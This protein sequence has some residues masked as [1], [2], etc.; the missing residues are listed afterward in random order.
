MANRKTDGWIWAFKRSRDLVTHISNNLLLLI[1][2]I[3]IDLL[4]MRDGKNILFTST[5]VFLKLE[6]SAW[7]EYTLQSSM[8]EANFNN[9]S[10]PPIVTWYFPAKH[11]NLTRLRLCLHV[12]CACPSASTSTSTLTLSQ[13]LTQGMGFR[14]ILCVC[15]CV[16]ISTT[17]KL[18][19][20]LTQMGTHTL[21]VNKTLVNIY[22]LKHG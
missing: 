19:L 13:W 22:W 21:R 10:S 3:D 12:T 5:I 17:L 9:S 18:T 16:T 14:P 1:Y 4:Q 6:D 20:T 8:T 11:I 7:L 2:H 15:V